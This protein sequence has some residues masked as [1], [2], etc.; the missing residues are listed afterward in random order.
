VGSGN[1]HFFLQPRTNDA[2][3]F[4]TQTGSSPAD[5]G[6]YIAGGITVPYAE[7]IL[8]E[9]H[10]KANSTPTASDGFFKM[11]WNGVLVESY[12]DAFAGG[13]IEDLGDK[14]RQWST[15]SEP[16][17]FGGEWFFWGGD[18]ATKSVNDY[19]D[20]GEFYVSGKVN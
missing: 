19:I 13:S 1:S 15:F 11:W 10:M 8:V 3:A 12:A 5:A 16:G 2:L 17:F 14:T 20:W 9:V 6:Y 18:G 7:W 4:A